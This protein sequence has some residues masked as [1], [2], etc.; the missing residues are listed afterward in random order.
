VT[1]STSGRIQTFE[2]DVESGALTPMDRIHVP[3]SPHN[4]TVDA[5]GGLWVSTHPHAFP[6]MEMVRNPDDVSPT[7]V[8]RI[9]PAAAEGQQVEDIYL[10]RGDELSGGTVAAR[11]GSN[12]FVVGSG[13]DHKLLLCTGASAPAAP[14]PAPA[15]S[16]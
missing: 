8:L 5:D 16:T 1:E 6:F 14:T 10:N 12:Q 7:Q 11:R 2:R 4:I 15:G 3:G 9:S 13:T